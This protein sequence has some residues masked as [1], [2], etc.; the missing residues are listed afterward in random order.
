MNKSLGTWQ[1]GVGI[2]ISLMGIWLMTIQTIFSAFVVL[3][4]GYVVYVGMKIKKG[5]HPLQKGKES[6]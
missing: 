5:N 1:I 3:Y 4:G 6:K 2:L